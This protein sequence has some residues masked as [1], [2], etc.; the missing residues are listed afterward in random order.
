MTKDHVTNDN[1]S[2]IERTKNVHVSFGM[3]LLYY[4]NVNL[5]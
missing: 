5:V 1:F 2:S 4:L 3:I